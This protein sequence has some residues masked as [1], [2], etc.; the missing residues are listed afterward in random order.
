MVTRYEE[1]VRVLKD[2]R[3]TVDMTALD[4]PAGTTGGPQG[5]GSSGVGM[6]GEGITQGR[7]VSA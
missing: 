6:F 3:F 5:R 1:A 2:P 7:P 4:A